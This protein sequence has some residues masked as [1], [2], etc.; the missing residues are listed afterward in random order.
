MIAIFGRY[1]V[2]KRLKVLDG[3]GKWHSLYPEPTPSGD[4][5]VEDG[6]VED[7]VKVIAVYRRMSS[8]DTGIFDSSIFD[9]QDYSS[10]RWEEDITSSCQIIK[11]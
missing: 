9:D 6:Y 2:P 5:C 4:W 7:V 11:W 10:H 3:N 1:P 8:Y